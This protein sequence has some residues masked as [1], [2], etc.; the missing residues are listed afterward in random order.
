MV[1]HVDRLGFWAVYL[2]NPLTLASLAVLGV[3]LW[4]VL[5]LLFGPPAPDSRPVLD[6]S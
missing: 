6:R 3:F 5:P 1:S 2:R 4:A